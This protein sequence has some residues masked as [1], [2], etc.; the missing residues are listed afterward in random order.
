MERSMDSYADVNGLQ[1]FYNTIKTDYD[2]SHFMRALPGWM[3]EKRVWSP[4]AWIQVA[5]VSGLSSKDPLLV[6]NAANTANALG[7]NCAP[8]LMGYYQTIHDKFGS[9]EDMIKTA[10]LGAIARFNDP[11][12]TSFLFDV[13]TEDRYPLLG[14]T[15]AALLGAM[16][17]SQSTL[18]LP[19][20]AEVSDTLDSLA[21]R[22][23]TLKEHEFKVKNI[24]A[25]QVRVNRLRAMIGGR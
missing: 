24:R 4:P 8:Q 3:A 2:L 14:G 18:Y 13:L 12:K 5:V 6:F 17:T 9:H 22:L 20:L 23:S 16:E 15:F 21:T 10:I 1:A 19:K 25:V 11:N 7:I